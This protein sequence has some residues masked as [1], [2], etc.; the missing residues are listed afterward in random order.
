MEIPKFSSKFKKYISQSLNTAP[1]N[2]IY[3][4]RLDSI[5]YKS[6]G[7]L[8]QMLGEVKLQITYIK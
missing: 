1:R 7:K 8:V 3:N 4:L 6:L 2:S 5:V